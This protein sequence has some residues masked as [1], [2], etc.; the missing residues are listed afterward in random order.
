MVLEYHSGSTSTAGDG[1][2]EADIIGHVG[3]ETAVG[4]CVKTEACVEGSERKVQMEAIRAHKRSR[5]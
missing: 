2:N 1:E 5:V 3:M 4:N